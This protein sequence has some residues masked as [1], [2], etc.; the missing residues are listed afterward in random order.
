VPV[1][2]AEAASTPL[3]LVTINRG[4]TKFSWVSS[5]RGAT[6]TFSPVIT[7]IDKP[8][9]TLPAQMTVVATA[10]VR[11]PSRTGSL[12]IPVRVYD[13]GKLV[14]STYATVDC[15]SKYA[16]SDPTISHTADQYSTNPHYFHV[17]VAIP[18]G[19]AHSLVL[20]ADLPTGDT[21]YWG[22]ARIDTAPTTGLMD[23]MGDSGA[24][25]ATVLNPPANAW[26]GVQWLDLTGTT[27]TMIDTWLYPLDQDINYGRTV[28]GVEPKDFGTGPYRWV[29]YA[30][31][32]A[33]GG[34][35]WGVSTPFYFPQASRDW[36]W[37]EIRQT[38]AK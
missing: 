16:Y 13:F 25:A 5:V 20:Q 1:S 3:V 19:G 27:W 2:A 33:E 34:K 29:V 12:N 30:G 11:C 18:S 31:N 17:N 22:Y 6:F 26:V 10:N 23:T 28:R 8:L 4:W 7:A 32:P 9:L 15:S 35:L 37:M 14:N 21:L 36:L 24:I 38:P